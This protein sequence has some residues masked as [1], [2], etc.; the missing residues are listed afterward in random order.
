[1]LSE[2]QR[3]RFRTAMRETLEGGAEEKFLK[4]KQLSLDNFNTIN[5]KSNAGS[6]QAYFLITQNG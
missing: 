1:M 2:S 6:K 5:L 4:K 3:I